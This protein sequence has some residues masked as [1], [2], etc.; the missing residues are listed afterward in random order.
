MPGGWIEVESKESR[1]NR[2]SD[3][4]REHREKQ[5]VAKNGGGDPNGATPISKAF[6]QLEEMMATQA[7]Q[8]R[9]KQEYH[10]ERREEQQKELAR[11]RALEEQLNRKRELAE[12]KRKEQDPKN[13]PSLAQVIN[14]NAEALLNDCADLLDDDLANTSETMLAQYVF[15]TIDK[16]CRQSARHHRT[17]LDSYLEPLES[18]SKDSAAMRTLKEAIGYHFPEEEVDGETTGFVSTTTVAATVFGDKGTTMFANHSPTGNG[19]L[20]AAQYLFARNPTETL[21]DLPLAMQSVFLN[22]KYVFHTATAFKNCC[23][24]LAQA[25]RGGKTSTS[26]AAHC[27]ALTNFFASCSVTEFRPDDVLLNLID[28]ALQNTTLDDSLTQSVHHEASGWAIRNLLDL[29]DSTNQDILT[30]I[31]LIVTQGSQEMSKGAKVTLPEVL[32]QVRAPEAPRAALALTLCEE[33][34]RLEVGAQVVWAERVVTSV[35][36][37]LVVLQSLQRKGLPIHAVFTSRAIIRLQAAIQ[38][39]TKDADSCKKVIKLLQSMKVT[40]GTPTTRG[41]NNRFRSGGDGDAEEDSA[42]QSTHSRSGGAGIVTLLFRVLTVGGLAWAA[43]TYGPK[44]PA[45]SA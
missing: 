35:D 37:T 33:F 7:E 13:W 23:F 44:F 40:S 24:V 34:T 2:L 14:E 8:K 17:V 31:A 12:K 30:R 11:K 3:A 22:P 1:R 28:T 20:L 26:R 25:Y 45:A 10:S 29:I 38:R 9:V 16:H 27:A 41:T 15:A 19:A 21:E 6:A 32:K 42:N 5:R 18:V 39:N 43:Y 4:R 36:D